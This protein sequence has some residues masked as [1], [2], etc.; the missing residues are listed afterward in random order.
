M[1]KRG[2]YPAGFEHAGWK[3]QAVFAWRGA[4]AWGTAMKVAAGLVA[5][6]PGRIKLLGARRWKNTVRNRLF[7]ACWPPSP[8]S[9]GPVSPCTVEEELLD[10]CFRDRGKEELEEE[11]FLKIPAEL[12]VEDLL[13]QH[14]Y[15]LSGG[16][17][18]RAALA[19]VLLLEPR[20]FA[21]QA[22]R[23]STAF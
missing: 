18:Q 17:Q 23:A 11:Q 4:T 22:P 3:R 21:G 1:K 2:R 5:T 14:P 19:K 12:Q 6:L 9:Q 8:E 16:E 13:A 7:R 20:F 10:G 15:D